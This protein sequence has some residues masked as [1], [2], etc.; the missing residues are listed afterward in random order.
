[1]DE[2]VAANR[3]PAWS[4]YKLTF[5]KH[6]GKKLEEVPFTYLVKYLIPRKTGHYECAFLGD[7]IDDFLKRHPHIKSQAG[8]AKTKSPEGWAGDKKGSVRKR[9]R[10][11]SKTAD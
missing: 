8:S 4:E 10:P 3:P 2:W 6:K 7:A 1:M 9:G 5:G 11:S